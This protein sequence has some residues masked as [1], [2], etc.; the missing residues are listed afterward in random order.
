VRQNKTNHYLTLK[1]NYLNDVTYGNTTWVWRLTLHP[2]TTQA[3]PTKKNND[4]KKA[5]RCVLFNSFVQVIVVVRLATILVV[6]MCEEEKQPK[7]NIYRKSYSCAESAIEQVA[8]KDIS[9]YPTLIASILRMHFHD[10]FVRVCKIWKY[11][12]KKT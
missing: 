2:T 3:R 5:S 6:P 7:H 10:S 12:K 1:T 8:K 9:T 11:G 4:I